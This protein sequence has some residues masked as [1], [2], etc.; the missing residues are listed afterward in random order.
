MAFTLSIPLAVVGGAVTF[1]WTCT[2]MALLLIVAL[3]FRFRLR[4]RV[5]KL[6]WHGTGKQPG[7]FLLGLLSLC[8][9]FGFMSRGVGLNMLYGAF[10]FGSAI[11]G[12]HYVTHIEGAVRGLTYR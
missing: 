11:S 5:L 1:F 7:L 6:L 2:S 10:I 4:E 8:L 3:V 12:T 9:I